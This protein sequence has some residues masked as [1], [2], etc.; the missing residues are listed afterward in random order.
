[1][2]MT[3]C[4]APSSRRRCTPGPPLEGLCLSQHFV[5]AAFPVQVW[6]E[7]RRPSDVCVQVQGMS[8][9]AAV[10]VLNLDT[11]DAFIAFSNLLN[12]PCQMAFFRVD[13][14]LVSTHTI[15]HEYTHSCL[16]HRQEKHIKQSS[17]SFDVF[18][19]WWCHTSVLHGFCVGFLPEVPLVLTVPANVGSSIKPPPCLRLSLQM[20]TYFSA[21]E[22]FFEE[23]LPKLFAHFK[24]N[25][26][27]PDIYL[28]DW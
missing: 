13:H 7:Q 27:T 4:K 25:N 18:G 9:I 12:K 21:F 11:A 1:M 10:L 17:Y 20:L 16:Q 22:V 24:K 3:S 2:S 15:P 8:F 6:R 28:I 26:L 14:S 19:F 23:N 5:H